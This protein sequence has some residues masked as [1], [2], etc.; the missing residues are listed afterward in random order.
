MS[1]EINERDLD[2]ML[3]VAIHRTRSLADR[4]PDDPL[5]LGTGLNSQTGAPE[6]ADH[7]KTP[8]QIRLRGEKLQREAFYMPRNLAEIHLR[9]PCETCETCRAGNL[10]ACPNAPAF[11]YL[12]P[13]SWS[14]D[15]AADVAELEARIH[16]TF[17]RWE[18]EGM[19]IRRPPILFTGGLAEESP[20]LAKEGQDSWAWT[21]TSKGLTRAREAFDL[22]GAWKNDNRRSALWVMTDTQRRN[23]P[24]WQQ[25]EFQDEGGKISG[26]PDARPTSPL[27]ATAC[28]RCRRFHTAAQPCP[29]PTV[30]GARDRRGPH[31]PGLLARIFGSRR[32]KK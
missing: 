11:R 13:L 6:S 20:Y 22:A 21:I 30:P 26:G 25:K 9:R 18:Q 4:Y 15:E 3:L 24:Q 8:G 14:A 7:L 29:G 12:D 28:P 5:A 1:V 10:G 27:L 31:K 2:E 17:S 32:K 19:M 16:A 23:A